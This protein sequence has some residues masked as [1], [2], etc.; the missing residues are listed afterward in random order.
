MVGRDVLKWPLGEDEMGNVQW[1][2]WGLDSHGLHRMDFDPVHKSGDAMTCLE[3]SG[4]G[5]TIHFKP[6]G[7]DG[8]K[9]RRYMV[10]VH[11]GVCCAYGVHEEF[12]RAA[13]AALL[14]SIPL[15]KELHL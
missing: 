9:E 3:K 4:L 13:I 15:R 10:N 6:E 11:V 7:H 14:K 2:P 12:S 5:F 8:K 1:F